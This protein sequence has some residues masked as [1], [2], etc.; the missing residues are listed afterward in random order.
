MRV[1]QLV[2]RLLLLFYQRQGHRL[3]WQD[4]NL[5][6]WCIRRIILASSRR[7]QPEARNKESAVMPSLFDSLNSIA[8]VL[9]L[10]AGAACESEVLEYK[11]A[12]NMES[13]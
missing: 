1:D 13:I 2:D 9:A 5:S 11:T 12:S 4:G 7:V 8:D 10:I 6:I 3:D